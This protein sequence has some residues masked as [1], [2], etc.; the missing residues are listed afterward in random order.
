[1][2]ELMAIS[3]LTLDNLAGA[4][5]LHHIDV[6]NAAGKVRVVAPEVKG[7][8]VYTNDGHMSVIVQAEQDLFGFATVA[9]AGTSSVNG[10]QITHRVTV[11]APPMSPGT[12]QVRT[13]SLAL[14]PAA[15]LSLSGR[16]GDSK[17]ILTWSREVE[18]PEIPP[19]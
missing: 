16:I 17:T 2:G 3:E 5:H 9:Y 19:S 7:L 10:D 4:W 1:M 11:G 18:R 12:V 13:A 14:F 6:D 15:N 8:L